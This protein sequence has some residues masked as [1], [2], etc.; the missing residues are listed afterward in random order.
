VRALRLLSLRRLRLQP[1]RA[2]LAAVV[3]GAGVSLVVA[4]VVITTSLSASVHEAGRALAGPAPVR[5][6]GPLSRGGLTAR[7]VRAISSTPGVQAAVPLI[8]GLSLVDRG[9]G[10]AQ[11]DVTVLGFDCRVEALFGP[12]GCDA[13]AL[14]ALRTPIVSDR[15]AGELRR[16]ATVATDVERIPLAGALRVRAIDALND[17][18]VVAFALPEAQRLL[19]RHDGTDVVYVVPERG[20]SAATL[21]SRLEERLGPELAVLSAT[22]EP[23][24]LGA[25]LVTF[26][27]LFSVIAVLT[28]AIGA[29]LVRNSVTLSLEERRRQTAIVGALG[30]SGSLLVWGTVAEVGVLGLIG[31]LLGIGGGVAV[32]IPVS[33]SLEGFTR[34][35]AGIPI[36]ITVRPQAVVVALVVGVAVSVLVALGPARRATRLDV[37]AE[38]AGRGRREDIAKAGSWPRIATALVVAI[39]CIALCAAAAARGGVERWQSLAAPGA[40]VLSSIASVYLVATLVPRFLAWTERRL[41]MR[42]A[43]TKL[44]LANLRREPR[45]TGVM[46]VALSFAVGVGFV[47]ASFQASVAK[48]IADSYEAHLRGV[49]V[50]SIDTDNSAMTDA[51]LPQDVLRRLADV[52]GVRR[53]DAGAFAVVG[54][55]S[56]Q[57]IGVQAYEDPFLNAPIA[58]GAVSRARLDA[59]EVT[60]GPALARDEHVGPGD[61]IRVGTPHGPVELPVMA[62]VYDGDFG[63][64]NIQ[65]SY[66]LLERVFG[67]QPPIAVQVHGPRGM[68]DAALKE[69]ILAAHLGPH[70]LVSTSAQV[71]ERTIRSVSTQLSA[72]DAL[73]R[74]LLVMSFIAVLSTLLLVGVQRTRELG[75]LAAVGMTPQELRRMILSEAGL[76]AVGGC[77]VGVLASLLQYTG[78]N[79]ITPVMIGYKD[80]W[81]I[82]P[83]SFVTY[84]LVAIAVALVAA[85]YPS[86]RAA[87]VEVLDA[88]RYE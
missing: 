87:R 66:D 1:L 38:L 47:T 73:Q 22:D 29:I 33:A 46:A 23:P 24:I 70:L 72:F 37:A 36:D 51:R 3:V 19:G 25:V 27:S 15:L 50:A 7:D 12:F 84:S 5:V 32:A 16:G 69:R 63:G 58:S 82:A 52:P 80:P 9:D 48:G 28:L 76:V 2:V 49:E 54:N 79:L 10:R 40:F 13:D 35:L 11:V 30:G 8:Q 17:G 85:L 77:V 71:E 83:V 56:G 88:L 20:V 74:G 43:S 86:R 34:K 67:P 18:R 65:M 6:V 59:G 61:R 53:I 4:I 57:L 55:R 44:A 21:Q 75:M 68:S 81:R 45:R 60:I 14:D 62:V 64:R 39:G 31:G 42:R 41:P 26:I 78:L